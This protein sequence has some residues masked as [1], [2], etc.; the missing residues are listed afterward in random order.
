MKLV[1]LNLSKHITNI[2]IIKKKI[3]KETKKQIC[4]NSIVTKEDDRLGEPSE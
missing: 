1:C 4:P 2:C 3:N